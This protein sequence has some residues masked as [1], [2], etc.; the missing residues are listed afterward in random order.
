MYRT[1]VINSSPFN[2][3]INGETSAGFL[4]SLLVST[5]NGALTRDSERHTQ[6]SLGTYDDAVLNLTI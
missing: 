6:T 4:A 1:I 2:P 5:E 3:F